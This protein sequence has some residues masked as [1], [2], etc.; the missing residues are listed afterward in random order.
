MD[1]KKIHDLALNLLGCR[2][3][4][5][6]YPIFLW[7]CY[8]LF[9]MKVVMEDKPYLCSSTCTFLDVFRAS[10]FDEKSLLCELFLQNIICEHVSTQMVVTILSYM[11]D[12]QL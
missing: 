6:S 4:S 8:F 2:R 12:L 11:G 1:S 10:D 9:Y 5:P 7:E 3:P